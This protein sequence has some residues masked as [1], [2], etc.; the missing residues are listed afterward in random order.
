MDG[1]GLSDNTFD[2]GN[3][4]RDQNADSTRVLY[5][6]YSLPIKLSWIGVGE[7][8]RGTIIVPDLRKWENP[9]VPIKLTLGNINCD[10]S[11]IAQSGDWNKGETARGVFASKM[12]KWTKW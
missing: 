8:M 7:G 9:E 5:N 4:K 3:L 11:S 2:K 10:G 1:K 6:E 12:L